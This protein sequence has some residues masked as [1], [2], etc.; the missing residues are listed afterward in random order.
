MW[1]VKKYECL[2]NQSVQANK[3]FPVSF[4]ILDDFPMTLSSK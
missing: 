3:L 1:W 4:G 2:V